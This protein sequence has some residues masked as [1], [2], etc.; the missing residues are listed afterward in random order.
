MKFSRRMLS[1]TPP[2]S[3]PPPTKPSVDFL[4][5]ELSTEAR[6][7]Q[8]LKK[9]ATSAGIAWRTVERTKAELGVKSSKSGLREGWVWELPKA[10]EARYDA[11]HS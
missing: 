11:R 5:E 1:G 8:D 4:R 9:A 7:A 6:P 10:A 2:P 3:P